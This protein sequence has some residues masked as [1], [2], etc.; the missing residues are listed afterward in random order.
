M[1]QQ[2]QATVQQPMPQPFFGEG[3]KVVLEV[4]ALIITLATVGGLL[5]K[6]LNS[7]LK[8]A[9]EKHESVHKVL[10]RD[11]REMRDDIKTQAIRIDPLYEKHSNHDSR[12]SRVETVLE[13]MDEKLNDGFANISKQLDGIVESIRE[14]R[15][16]D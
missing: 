16:K 1:P 4:C 12:I 13:K 15:K 2:T 11:M 10:D 5:A 6:W 9:I 3:G 14:I 7:K 8:D